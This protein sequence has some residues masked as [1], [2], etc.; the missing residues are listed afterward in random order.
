MPVLTIRRRDYECQYQNVAT[1]TGLSSGLSFS[2]SLSLS[3]TTN[4]K[5]IANTG[6]GVALFSID[7]DNKLSNTSWGYLMGAISLV[8]KR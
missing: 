7:A 6:V 3:S 1:F 2:F 5:W 4:G 8:S